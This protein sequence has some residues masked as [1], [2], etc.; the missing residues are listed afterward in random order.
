M[1][2]EILVAIVVGLCQFA[3]TT[4]VFVSLVAPERTPFNL[5]KVPLFW[6]LACLLCVSIV[7]GII[8]RLAGVLHRL[9]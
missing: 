3:L 8:I 5:E 6:R 9:N 1:P 7:A 4:A 2:V